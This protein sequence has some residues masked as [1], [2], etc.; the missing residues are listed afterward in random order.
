MV[1]LD[2]VPGSARTGAG[3]L[4]GKVT[5]EN[6]NW[7]QIPAGFTYKEE[8]KIAPPKIFWD[9]KCGTLGP[10]AANPWTIHYSLSPRRKLSP[11]GE[12]GARHRA[13]RLR[14]RRSDSCQ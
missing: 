11:K 6:L 2:D 14:E 4:A 10:S 12:C 1:E 8:I 13:G 7:V 5:Y 9:T 3:F